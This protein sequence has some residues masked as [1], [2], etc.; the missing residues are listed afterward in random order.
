MGYASINQSINR[1]LKGILRRFPA[2]APGS[3]LDPLVSVCRILIFCL[4]RLSPAAKTR[5]RGGP[6]QITA[7]SPSLG[8]YARDHNSQPPSLECGSFINKGSGVPREGITPRSKSPVG[9]M[10]PSDNR[11]SLLN[12]SL[13]QISSSCIWI[14]HRVWL[15]SSSLSLGRT[16]ATSFPIADSSCQPAQ[17]G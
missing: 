3:S 4:G 6:E 8:L 13:D 7:P 2:E 1:F 10:P 12:L 17:R 14:K 9:G 15:G 5:S 16:P 11:C